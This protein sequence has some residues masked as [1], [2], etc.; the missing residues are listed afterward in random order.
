MVRQYLKGWRGDSW[1]HAQSAR[2]VET[3]SKRRSSAY[4]LS[5]QIAS[6]SRAPIEEPEAARVPGLTALGE[7][8]AQPVEGGPQTLESA[9]TIQKAPILAPARELPLARVTETLVPGISPAVPA[10]PAIDSDLTIGD[11]RHHESAPEGQL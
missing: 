4:D 9:S 3:G 7:Q 2:G 5:Y 10:E 8:Q 1:R 11:W 6:I